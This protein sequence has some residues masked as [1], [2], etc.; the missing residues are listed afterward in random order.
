MVNLLQVTIGAML[1]LLATAFGACT[2]VGIGD[3]FV[4]VSQYSAKAVSLTVKNDCSGSKSYSVS[5]K[6][7]VPVT[8][9]PSDF[10]L[11]KGATKT[12]TLTVSPGSLDAGL[13]EAV[14]RV[15]SSDERVDKAFAI[16]VLQSSQR[17]LSLDVPAFMRVEEN[18]PVEVVVGLENTGKVALQNV[19]V[20]VEEEG[21]APVDY[22]S[23]LTLQPEEKQYITLTL[24]S[25]SRGSYTLNVTAVS[26]TLK[27][28]RQIELDVTTGGFPVISVVRVKEGEGSYVVK[29]LAKNAG[30]RTLTNLFLTVQDAPPEWEI[31]SPSR[32]T[33]RAGESKEV[34]LVLKYDE[35]TDARV[36]LA[37]F[38][39]QALL[40]EDAVELSLAKL[41]GTGLISFG[42]SVILGLFALIVLSLLYVNRERIDLRVPELRAPQWLKSLWPF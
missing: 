20:R 36:N 11:S 9:E 32:F 17:V 14:A 12:V 24:P 27:M 41:R 8:A 15:A 29:Y 33:L 26:G 25:R 37:L 39:G 40:T 42:G 7:D 19:L 21:Q 3:E 30:S 2:S 1:L 5:V 23:L 28:R 16:K 31:I 6:S 10:T 35:T 13:Y 18:K 38:E 22:K 34:E 4:E